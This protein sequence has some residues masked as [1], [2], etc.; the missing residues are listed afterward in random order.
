MKESIVPICL[1]FVQTLYVYLHC[2]LDEWGAGGGVLWKVA[3]LD[4]CFVIILF[5]YFYSVAVKG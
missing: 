2:A 4:H 3:V 5:W 1:E